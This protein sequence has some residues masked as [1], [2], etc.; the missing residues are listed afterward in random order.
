M[1][2]GQRAQRGN[3]Q[4]ESLV[5]KGPRSGQWCR[6]HSRWKRSNFAPSDQGLRICGVHARAFTRGTLVEIGT[7]G[8]AQA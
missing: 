6:W 1:T 5:A 7:P 3:G 8:W 2:D 4:C